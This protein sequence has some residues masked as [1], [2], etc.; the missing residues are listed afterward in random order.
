VTDPV[1]DL[2]RS[3][4]K[5]LAWSFANTIILRLGSLIVGIVL[6][7]LLTP[8][9][10]GIYAVALAVQSILMTLADLGLS[11]D[12]VRSRDP[13]RREPTVATL[14]LGSGVLLTALMA[15]LASPLADAMGT[16]QAAPV[17]VVLSGTL[18]LSSAGVVPYAR[19]QR[20]FG[21]RE[22]FASGAVDFVVSTGVTLVLVL[23]G[24]GPMALAIARLVAQAS[25]TAVQFILSR[26]RP[27]FGFDRS[28]AGPALRFGLPLAGANLLS[29]ALLNVDNIVIAR[30][31]G[32]VALGFYVLA[33]NVSSWPMTAI[34]TAIR[35][36]SLA[37]FS[38]TTADRDV[39]GDHNQDP[40]L[41]IATAY[42]WAAALPAGALLA[43][44][45]VPVIDLLYGEKWQSA[46]PILAALGIFGALRVVFDLMATYLMARGA[47][48]PVLWIQILWIV[49]LVPAMM[50][51]IEF[52]GLPG[53]GWAHVVVAAII[54]LPAYCWALRGVQAAIKPVLAVLWPPMLAAAAGWIAADYV[55]SRQDSPLPALL[56]GGTCGLLVYAG[57]IYKWL[58]GFTQRVNRASDA[59]SPAGRAA[60]QAVPIDNTLRNHR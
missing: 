33:F 45:A 27:Q 49:A 17:I 21:Q 29:W 8:E 28:I 43:V 52:F 7:R 30:A 6:A 4:R 40:G 57:L 39:A 11:A 55:A 3:V 54:I 47:A 31:A 16:P 9:V 36:V 22:L 26:T 60:A 34:G 5:G 25:A 48:R 59:S 58:R 51:A 14:S 13:G 10:F 32:E 53:A 38:R 35:S 56:L 20:R 18:I 44:L 12:L 41:A 2:G 46:A 24:M 50:L 42:A 23:A 1:Q 15:A 37:A 19:L